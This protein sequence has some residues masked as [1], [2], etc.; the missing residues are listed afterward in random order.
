MSWVRGW[1]EQMPSRIAAIHGSPDEV[2][3]DNPG[4]PEADLLIAWQGTCANVQRDLSLLRSEDEAKLDDPVADLVDIATAL[5]TADIAVMRGERE[6]WPRAIDLTIPVRRVDLWRG[7]ADRFQRLVHEL[8]RDRFTL[9]FDPAEADMLPPVST[10]EAAT[11]E[12]ADCVC[13]L[14]GGLDSLA[15]AVMLQTTGRRPV[16]SL[17]RSGNPAVLQ[18]QERVLGA[19]DAHWPETSSARPCT[20][21]PDPRGADT[22]AYPPPEERESSRRCRSLLYMVLALAT[23]EAAGLD[24][25]FMCENGVLT[26]GLPLTSS[27]VGSMSTHSTHPMALELMNR[28][29][30]AAGM[31]ATLRNPFVYQTKAE[32]IRDI[33]VPSLTVDEIQGTVS[34]WAAGRANRQCGGCV[35]CLLR[36]LGM[37]WAQLPPEAYMVDVLK[38]PEDYVGTDSYANLVDILRHAEQI[39]RRDSSDL[40]AGYPG[41]LALHSAGV[42]VGEITEMLKRHADQTLAV[43]RDRYPRAAALLD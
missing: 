26:A 22:L 17:H 33:L 10:G 42:D 35:P 36:Q 27:R 8:T 39:D 43:V 21:E 25:V 3:T 34:C 1:A 19:L 16:Y 2:A 41:L 4:V 11:T 23:A 6:D 38:R 18:A 15:G 32:L 5:Y 37:A 29:V 14:S 7:L 31:S 9:N 24:E 40:I 20:I 13:M 28:I 30:E 12:D